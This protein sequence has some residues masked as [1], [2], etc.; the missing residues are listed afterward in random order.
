MP[1]KKYWWIIILVLIMLFPAGCRMRATADDLFVGTWSGHISGQGRDNMLAIV[2]SGVWDSSFQMEIG[3]I[4][5]GPR[6]Q[7]QDDITGRPIRGT[8]TVYHD[9]GILHNGFARVRCGS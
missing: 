4:T 8:A 6:M 7:L 2:A 3:E 5:I 1:F 9:C